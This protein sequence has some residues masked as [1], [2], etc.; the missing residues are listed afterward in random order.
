VTAV[1]PVIYQILVNGV[2]FKDIGL[3]R[4]AE[5]REAFGDHDLFFIRVDYPRTYPQINLVTT[6]AN[7]TPIQ[8]TWG[9]SPDL[10]I[11]YG[12]VNH[13][14]ISSNS[15]AG[16]N[17]QQVNYVLIG[18]SA[19]L[20]ID[21]SRVWRNV[22]PTY[23]A[24]QIAAENKMR[25][26][27]TPITTVLDYEVQAGES[28]F[29]FMNRIAD[30]TG[31]RFWCS[32]GTLYLLEPA[33]ALY[34][35][36]SVS[37]AQFT[38]SKQMDVQDTVRNFTLLQGT[39]LPGAVVANRT[40]YGVDAASGAIISATAAPT[41]GQPTSTT[42]A[43]NAIT[44]NA[45]TY[46]NTVRPVTSQSEALATVTAWQNLSQYWVGATCQLFGNT[47]LYPGKLVELTGTGLM[48]GMAGFWLITSARHV[49]KAS[50]L[51]YPVLDRYLV[52][53]EIMRNNSG[54]TVLLSGE[55]RVTPEMVP[56]TLN[57]GIW[58]SGNQGIIRTRFQR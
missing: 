36:A 47:L 32:G 52:D 7:N 48:D 50:G 28:D 3:V 25:T 46:I 37:V 4:D 42:N 54:G 53:V 44:S 49:L 6:W 16:T 38:F 20:N 9:R 40:V 34:G 2:S 19:Y 27:V 21:R 10:N 15:D 14:E 1:G 26:V 55:Q 11:W 43:N 12:Y 8:V 31:M 58:S 41:T 18:T 33:I 51:A 22:S 30:K 23:I 56:M 24:T 17:T 45:A 39:N 13:S 5:L 35:T 57:A 29:V